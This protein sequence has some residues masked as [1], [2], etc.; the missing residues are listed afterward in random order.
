MRIIFL[1]LGTLLVILFT[2]LW[3]LFFLS[4]VNSFW[5]IFK[6]KEKYEVKDTVPPI[7]PYVET[8]PE[9]IKEDKIN[10]MGKSESN[11]KVTLYVDEVK[12]NEVVADADGNFLFSDIPV[13]FSPTS[14]YITATDQAGNVSSKSRTYRIY[15]DNEP[16]TID[17]TA[18]KKN[19]VYKATERTYTVKGKTEPGAL[20][21]INEQL[22]LVDTEGAFTA[23]VNLKDG[24]NELKIKVDD[25]AGNETEQKIYVTFEKIK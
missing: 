8:I 6:G 19:E 1:N 5:E 4:H 15:R 21:Y 16:P 17:I 9:A 12:Q 20:V 2:Y 14:I 11:T 25:K 7:S 18:P 13:G 24:G 3:M 23:L 10:I 22:A